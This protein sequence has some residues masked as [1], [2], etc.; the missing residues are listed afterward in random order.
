MSL[1][2][3]QLLWDVE[4]QHLGEAEF[5]FEVREAALDAPDVVLDDLIR[6]L[7]RRLA[8]HVD[9]LALAGPEVA[10][11]LLRPVLADPNADHELIAA[12]TL[13]MQAQGLVE[14]LLAALD[15]DEDEPRNAVVAGL[16]LG[17]D[18]RLEAQI[19]ASL[20]HA[21]GPGAA[22][23]LELLAGRQVALGE[24]LHEFLAAD[25][26]RVLRAAARLARFG[27]PARTL[28]ALAPL[29]HSA[30]AELRRI[31][32]ETALCRG[33]GGAWESAIYWAFCPDES[34]FRR[35]ALTWV[36]LLGDAA[37]HQRL[38]AAVEVPEWRADALWAL[39]FTGRPAAVDRCVALLDDAELGPLAAEVVGAITGLP[40]DEP[41]YWCDRPA[42]T[43]DEALPELA[44]DD[45]DADLIPTGEDAL[46]VPNAEAIARW[47]SERRGAFDP[48]L[49]YL[50]GA[51]F[52][53]AALVDAL[54]R[55][56]MR[57]RHALALELALRTQGAVF[58]NTRT[59]AHHQRAQ[60]DALASLA[61]IDCQRGLAP[62]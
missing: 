38:L 2:E 12:A 15:I 40:G 5:I 36:A 4:E 23:R 44:H 35:D 30:D 45:L 13:A 10:R 37:A 55:G 3:D 61:A 43:A 51:I 39:G 49:R 34:P 26:L 25:D 52:D 57:R 28:E 24:R 32:L 6:G 56:P 42:T 29:A 60:L 8:A 50:G 31:T 41:A 58:V 33:L 18:P 7:D 53:G 1:R 62:G 19:L 46:P 54:G 14:P 16:V 47:W 9:A 17:E 21:Q 59:W 48:T 20:D 11:T 27:A 22:A